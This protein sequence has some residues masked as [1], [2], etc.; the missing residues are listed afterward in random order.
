MERDKIRSDMIEGYEAYYA[1]SDRKSCPYSD[2]T[3]IVFGTKQL[4]CHELRK[5]WLRGWDIANKELTG[6]K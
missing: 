1:G 3:E 2:T 6:R 4:S 5:F